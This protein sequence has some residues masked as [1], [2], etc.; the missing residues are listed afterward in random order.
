ME[1]G[2]ISDKVAKSKYG[3]VIESV[4]SFYTVNDEKTAKLR[5]QGSVNEK[6]EIDLGANRDHFE[7]HWPEEVM[8]QLIEKLQTLAPTERWNK[9]VL[10][11][12]YLKERLQDHPVSI[13]D[14]DEAW[15]HA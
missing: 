3:V 11:Q 13:A 7:R 2:L 9:K 10:I 6:H 4:G 14:I 8:D 5:S 12:N 15:H 1:M